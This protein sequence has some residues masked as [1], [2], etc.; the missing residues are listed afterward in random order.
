MWW[1]WITDHWIISMICAG[2]IFWGQVVYEV[3]KK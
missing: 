3:P 1:N 2:I